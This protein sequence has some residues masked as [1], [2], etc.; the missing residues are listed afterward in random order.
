M[1]PLARKPLQSSSPAVNSGSI[2]VSVPDNAPLF[3]LGHL[4]QDQVING[5]TEA[6]Y[7]AAVDANLTLLNYFQ[8][9]TEHPLLPGEFDEKNK[10]KVGRVLR[11]TARAAFETPKGGNLKPIK[12][13]SQTYF[14]EQQ[15]VV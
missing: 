5:S 7:R 6:V 14:Q 9:T 1:Q 8:I 2:P 10:T 15:G 11:Q 13:E 12:V 3:A 4:Q